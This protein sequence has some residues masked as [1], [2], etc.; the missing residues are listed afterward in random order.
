MKKN[1]FSDEID[2]F[3]PFL[4]LKV[5]LGHYMVILINTQLDPKPVKTCFYASLWKKQRKVPFFIYDPTALCFIRKSLSHFQPK[6]QS[7]LAAVLFE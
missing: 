4:S 1:E 7:L 3:N 6:Q 5:H 2:F